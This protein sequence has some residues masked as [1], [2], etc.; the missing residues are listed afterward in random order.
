VFLGTL[1]DAAIATSAG[2][3]CQ[4][5]SGGGAVNPLVDPH[6]GACVRWEHSISVA[7]ADC[8]TA[9][10]LTKVVRLAPPTL[11]SVLECFDAQAMIDTGFARR[12]LGAGGFR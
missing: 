8:M 1:T 11:L 6:G 2:Y 12:R 10:A 9:D 7:A 4:L 3:F 5:D